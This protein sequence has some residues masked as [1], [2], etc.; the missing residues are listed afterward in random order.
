[1]VE[2]KSNI[3]VTGIVTGALFGL[4]MGISLGLST[5][6]FSSG[7]NSGTTLGIFFGIAMALFLKYQYSKH[8]ILPDALVAEGIIAHGP[9]NH[10]QGMEGRGGWLYLTTRGLTFRPHGQNLSKM[11]LT[12]PLNEICDWSEH[13][14]MGIIPNGIKVTKINGVN[15]RYVV[16]RRNEWL[17]AIAKTA[18]KSSVNEPSFP[19][20]EL[21]NGSLADEIAKLEK[22]NANGVLTA[23]E[24]QKAKSKLLAS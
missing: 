22:L 1:M 11:I 9:A 23:D 5:T 3:V 13:N 16:S 10:F 8:K 18:K 19:K 21:T 17:D 2:I 6:P 4:F 20:F 14:H 7:F 24:Y 12:I 15:E